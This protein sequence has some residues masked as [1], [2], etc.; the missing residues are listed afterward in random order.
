MGSDVGATGCNG[1]AK[2]EEEHDEDCEDEDELYLGSCLALLSFDTAFSPAF[3]FGNLITT[4]SVSSPT[5]E[6]FCFLLR[7]EVELD[8]SLAATSFAR[9]FDLVFSLGFCRSL[10]TFGEDSL[11][12]LERCS[13]II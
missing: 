8:I 4:L 2:A 11:W 13:G 12:L 3:D 6:S 10:L 5:L 1:C 9:S 7:D